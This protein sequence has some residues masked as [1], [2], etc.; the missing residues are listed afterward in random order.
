MSVTTFP[1]TW[2][3]S[4]TSAWFRSK[5]VEARTI[6]WPGSHAVASVSRICV[7]PDIAVSAS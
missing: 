3:I 5:S 6:S 2:A 4:R 1:F 7:S